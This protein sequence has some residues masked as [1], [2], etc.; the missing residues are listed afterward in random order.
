MASV[1]T[2]IARRK[3]KYAADDVVDEYLLNQVA[4]HIRYNKLE[5]L[6]TSLN[7]NYMNGGSLPSNEHVLRVRDRDSNPPLAV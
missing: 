7:V 2:P 4:A 3:D 1:L 5:S 6:A